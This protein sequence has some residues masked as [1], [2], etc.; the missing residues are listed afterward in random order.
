[1]ITVVVAWA[2]LVATGGWAVVLVH[3]AWAAILFLAIA[4]LVGLIGLFVARHQLAKT[5]GAWTYRAHYGVWWRLNA[6]T[7]FVEE[8]PYCA[9]CEPKTLLNAKEWFPDLVLVCPATKTEYRLY[10]GA[11]H[12]PTVDS[13][14]ENLRTAYDPAI[15]LRRHL[16]DLEYRYRSR[17][18]EST[19]D[20]AR[21]WLLDQRPLKYLTRAQ[22]RDLQNTCENA[23]LVIERVTRHLDEYQQVLKHYGF[24]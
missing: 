19:P 20:L 4:A 11:V 13:A 21:D 2:A 12:V 7:G 16:Y 17:N 14:V 24:I 23:S 18:P 1:L 8:M 5:Q 6:R 22:R 3:P 9:C 10:E 15:S